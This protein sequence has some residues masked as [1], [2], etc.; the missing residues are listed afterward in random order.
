MHQTITSL[1]TDTAR[2]PS[3][4]T[5]QYNPNKVQQ[6]LPATVAGTRN[7]YGAFATSCK[8]GVVK[9]EWLS[10][11]NAADMRRTIGA[12]LDPPQGVATP[13]GLGYW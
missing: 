5:V 7:P 2:R 13:G 3:P 9:F 11:K 10:S 8:N 6:G 1:A 12:V 4:R